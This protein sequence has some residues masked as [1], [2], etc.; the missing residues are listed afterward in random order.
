MGVA[1]SLGTPE[2]TFH[3]AYPR[4]RG[5]KLEHHRTASAK[6]DIFRCVVF[7]FRLAY[8]NLVAEPV[9]DV[10]FALPVVELLGRNPLGFRQR[11]L[12]PAEFPGGL[13]QYHQRRD[14]LERGTL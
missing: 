11:L 8:A 7:C 1:K 4:S 3:C 2:G 14:Q 6:R 5:I 10:V 12:R 9:G 13:A